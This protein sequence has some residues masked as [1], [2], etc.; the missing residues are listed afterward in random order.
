MTNKVYKVLSDHRLTTDQSPPLWFTEGL[1]EY[2][3][4]DPDEQAEM[5]IRDAILNNYFFGIEDIY[6]HL[7]FFLYV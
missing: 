1:A 4:T 7:R 6:R 3:S 2:M 5:V